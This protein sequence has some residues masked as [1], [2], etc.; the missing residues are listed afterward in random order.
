MSTISEPLKA[1]VAVAD[2]GEDCIFLRVWPSAES[3][4]DPWG[5]EFD[6]C[7]THPVDVGLPPPHKPG[8]WV[9]EGCLHYFGT[10]HDADDPEWRGHW[11][12]ALEAEVVDFLYTSLK[13][14][15][16]EPLKDITGCDV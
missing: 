3:V 12:R 11:R 2:G 14:E 7:G 5:C 8:F 10:N 6:S 16:R 4:N 13:E 1:L 15:P 9:W